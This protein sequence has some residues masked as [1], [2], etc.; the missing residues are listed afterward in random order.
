M[1]ILGRT[2]HEWKIWFSPSR[3]CPDGRKHLYEE[4]DYY[5]PLVCAWCGDTRPA[6]ILPRID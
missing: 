4:Q 2:V 1:K 6:E 3:Y 5:D